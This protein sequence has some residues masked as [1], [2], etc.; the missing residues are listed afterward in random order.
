MPKGIA[1]QLIYNSLFVDLIEQSN[2]GESFSYEI[3][4]GVNLLSEKYNT[5]KKKG[6]IT[7]TEF[8]SL[9]DNSPKRGVIYFIQ[10]F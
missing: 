2:Y 3:K 9:F 10:V 4:K 5:V 6:N 8:T 1:A 7:A